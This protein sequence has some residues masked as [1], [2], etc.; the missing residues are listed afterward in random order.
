[1][2]I[3]Y[4]IAGAVIVLLV[5]WRLNLRRQGTWV[6]LPAD[7]H[8]AVKPELVALVDWV[9]KKAEEQI[10]RGHDVS[11]NAIAMSA[12]S[13]AA[14]VA[15]AEQRDDGQIEIAIP[16]FIHDVE[17]AHGFHVKIERARLAQFNL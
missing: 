10:G 12:I 6:D 2:S 7:P 17:G 1:M 4:W 16:E 15:L 13:Q 8:A 3:G 11:G 14:E 5:A 9:A